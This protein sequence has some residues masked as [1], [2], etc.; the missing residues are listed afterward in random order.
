[1]G[2]YRLSIYFKYQF[3]LM[4]KYDNVSKII[5]IQIPFIQF[6]VGLDKNAHGF[7]LIN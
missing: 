2:Q 1:M 7:S 5:E 3:G 4:L 6:L